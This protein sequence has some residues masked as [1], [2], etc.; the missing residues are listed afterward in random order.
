MHPAQTESRGGQ[1]HSSSNKKAEHIPMHGVLD[2]EGK[3][4][5][6]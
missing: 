6:C 3:R 5:T 2:T 1:F 4:I